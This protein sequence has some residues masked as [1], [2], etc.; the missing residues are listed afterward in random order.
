MVRRKWRVP[1]LKSLGIE[2]TKDQYGKLSQICLVTTGSSSDIS[3]MSDDSDMS[4]LK[5]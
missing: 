4:K 5:I 2:E 1:E 3:D